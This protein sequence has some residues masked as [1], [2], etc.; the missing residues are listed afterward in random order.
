[1]LACFVLILVL[2]VATFGQS[3]FAG[4]DFCSGSASG[5]SGTF[6]QQIVQNA[7]VTVGDIPRGVVNLY[8]KLASDSDVDIQ[9]YDAENGTAIVK[10]SQMK[11]FSGILNGPYKQ[12]TNYYA[13]TVEWSGYNGDGTGLGHEYIKITGTT[14]RKLTMKAFGYRA[15][16]ATVNY[17][18]TGGSAEGCSIPESGGGTFQQQIFQDDIVPVG[19]I[20]PGVNN[21]YINLISD[22]DVDIQLYDKDDGTK[23]VGWKGGI[24]TGSSTQ[25]TNYRNMSIEWSGYNGDGINRGHEYIKIT[26]TTTR[27]LTM[28]AFGYVAGFATVEYSW[29]G[30]ISTTPILTRMSS[31]TKHV[32]VHLGALGYKGSNKEY[33]SIQNLEPVLQK[34]AEN[35]KEYAFG[36]K[37][38]KA[39]YAGNSGQAQLAVQIEITPYGF[40]MDGLTTA[41]NK[42][43]TAINTFTK[44]GFAVHLLISSHGTPYDENWQGKDWKAEKTRWTESATFAPYQP[45]R[46][47]EQNGVVCPYDVIFENFHQPLLKELVNQK[48][49][50]KLAVIYILNEFDYDENKPPKSE[51]WGTTVCG[52]QTN[53]ELCRAEALAYTAKRGF[54]IANTATQSTVPIGIKFMHFHAN[55]GWNDVAGASQL[56]HLLVDVLGPNGGVVGYDCY[57]RDTIACQN[58]KNRISSLLEKNGYLTHFQNGRIEVTEYGCSCT[59]YP[60]Q[61]TTGR[62]TSVADMQQIVQEWNMASGFNLFAYTAS[63]N[64]TGCYAL[65]GENTLEVFESAKA[66]F[67]GLKKQIEVITG[68]VI[69]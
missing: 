66:T 55:S 44:E 15:G 14:T 3:V 46:L 11:E 56:S 12:T 61:F 35:I 19:D 59:G 69:N 60:E 42:L 7:I 4:F 57:W 68:L 37:T 54:N 51:N 18:W 50:E 38:A 24:L 22:N 39:Y 53:W 20:P 64:N 47:R 41:V 63:G 16:F 25:S 40:S 58:D 8:I 10:W 13:M 17:S 26:G 36:S 49:T 29:G 9:L 62:R 67:G 52:N 1:M 28:K 34:I 6:Q 31:T 43:R 23:I 27:N 65:A 2:F 5:G 33:L 45:C 30:G 21:L 32:G 48:L